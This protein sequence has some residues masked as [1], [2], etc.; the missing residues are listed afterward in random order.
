MEGVV[1]VVHAK[2]T[3]G[4]TQHQ[5]RLALVAATSTQYDDNIDNMTI[6]VLGILAKTGPV[7]AKLFE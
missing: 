6:F 7:T 3:S 1:W 4:N 5:V 2:R